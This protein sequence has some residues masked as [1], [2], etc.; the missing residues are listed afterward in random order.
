[1]AHLIDLAIVEY[2]YSHHDKVVSAR[3]PPPC[4]PRTAWHMLLPNKGCFARA[5]M[6]PSTNTL[7]MST[8]SCLR[9]MSLSG[10]SNHPARRPYHCFDCTLMPMM[11]S[12]GS[13]AALG[14]RRA[15]PARRIVDPAMVAIIECNLTAIMETLALLARPHL[16][17]SHAQSPARAWPRFQV[18]S[19]RSFSGIS[20]NMM[21]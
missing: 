17:R 1:M 2:A 7:A 15:V 13:A 10:S 18:K 19:V 9:R 14:S 16:P 5:D 21:I 12:H 3:S 4:M 6:I 11:R 20:A 8:S